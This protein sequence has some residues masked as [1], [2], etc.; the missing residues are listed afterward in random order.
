MSKLLYN[1]FYYKTL[2]TSFIAPQLAVG[3]AFKLYTSAP[4]MNKIPE[5]EVEFEKNVPY[6]VIKVP[7]KKHIEEMYK[8]KENK[9]S[10][11]YEIFLIPDLPEE[12]S[13]LEYLPDPNVPKREETIICCHGW[14]GRSFNFYKFIPKLQAKGFRVLAPDFPQHGKTEAPCSGGHTFGHSINCLIRYINGPVY[15]LTH[16]LGNF[17]FCYNYALSTQ[18]ERNLVKRYVGIAIPNEY[19]DIMVAFE[20]IIG[21]SNRCHPYFVEENVKWLGADF[22]KKSVFGEILSHYNIPLLFIH[23]KNDKELD[24]NKAVKT[25]SFLKHKNY[26]VNGE[27]KPCFFESEGLGHRRI[28]RDDGIVD[29]VVEFFAENIEIQD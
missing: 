7:F 26:K 28:L 25:A 17:G 16:S 24:F 14:G 21:L 4:P 10:T 8:R 15:I 2:T 6:N 9:N 23:D 11:P 18:Q 29:R 22:T 1:L 27:I 3:Q 13:V 12:L 19:N 5:W 20:N